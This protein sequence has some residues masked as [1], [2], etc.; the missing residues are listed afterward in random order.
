[1]RRFSPLR[2]ATLVVLAALFLCTFAATARSEEGKLPAQPPTTPP[3]VTYLLLPGFAELRTENVQ[4]ELELT[5]QQ[6]E[7]LI[8]IG[9]KYYEETR[10]DWA[11]LG[12]MSAEERKEKYAEIREK[13]LKRTQEIRKQV[14]EL[15]SPDQLERLKQINLRTRGTAALLNPRILDELGITEAQRNRLRQLREQLQE[16]IRQLQQET[17]EKT[18]E[19]LTPEQRKKLEELTSEGQG[20]YGTG[21]TPGTP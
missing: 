5:D 8:A 21:Q 4:K 14:E 3:R 2:T 18:L 7:Q 11:G 12:G 1:M 9:Q 10:R 16:R 17:L 6:K 13:N 15:L 19:V 20:I